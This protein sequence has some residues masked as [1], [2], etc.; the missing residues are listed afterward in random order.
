M[1]GMRVLFPGKN[2][3]NQPPFNLPSDHQQQLLRN[4]AGEAEVEE[5]KVFVVE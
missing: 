1:S 4:G 2:G 5:G 3:R